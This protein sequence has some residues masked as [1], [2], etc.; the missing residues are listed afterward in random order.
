MTCRSPTNCANVAGRPAMPV[1]LTVFGVT[2]YTELLRRD[3]AAGGMIRLFGQTS[4]RSAEATRKR[5]DR[6]RSRRTGPTEQRGCRSQ[7]RGKKARVR[8]IEEPAGM[9]DDLREAERHVWLAPY[10]PI[11]EEVSVGPWSVIPFRAF[12]SGRA[13]SREVY[14]DAR[15]LITAYQVDEALLRLGGVI[16]PTDGRVGDG[17]DA[18]EARTLERAIAI[19][20]IASNP[21]FLDDENPNAAHVCSS[22]DNA[23]IVGYSLRPGGAFAFA[24][25]ALVPRVNLVSSRPGGRLP[26]RPTPIGLPRPILK[27]HFDADYA[28]ELVTILLADSQAA[29][30]I[31][32]CAQWLILG[33]SNSDAIGADARILAFRAAFEVLL[34]GKSSAACRRT[35]SRLLRDA[36]EKRERRW[37][38]QGRTECKA[39]DDTEWWF[40]S[41]TLLRNE[42]VHGEAVT[43]ERWLFEDGNEHLWHADDRLRA[44]IKREAVRAGADPLIELDPFSRLIRRGL[45]VADAEANTS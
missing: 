7:P 10:L 14:R 42:I 30:R 25:G 1:R 22:S 16:C 39:L 3:L 44:A 13:C 36:S 2:F 32:R 11:S 4:G 9:H 28:T 31:D 8:C 40:Q 34:G 12:R 17:L 26:R 18:Q 23:R 15:R 5:G 33:W 43:R 19:S 27:G 38:D 29:R 21:S 37:V 6:R 24:E 45:S 35:L 20:L 41:F